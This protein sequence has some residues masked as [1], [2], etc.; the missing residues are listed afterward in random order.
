MSQ[1]ILQLFSAWPVEQRERVTCLLSSC[2]KGDAPKADDSVKER[3][4]IEGNG[5]E[6]LLD[7]DM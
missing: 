6:A 3:R 4:V 7:E 1:E 5:I 2:S